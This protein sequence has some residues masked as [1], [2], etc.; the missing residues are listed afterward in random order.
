MLKAKSLSRLRDSKDTARTPFEKGGLIFS[1]RPKGETGENLKKG[2]CL[3]PSKKGRGG[4]PSPSCVK[5]D[6]TN[7]ML[8][9]SVALGSFIVDLKI[10]SYFGSCLF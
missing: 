9:S 8:V 10:F 5:E 2:G 6:R 4:D 1:R 7:T 3:G